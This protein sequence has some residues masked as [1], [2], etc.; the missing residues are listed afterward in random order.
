MRES[1]IEMNCERNN[2]LPKPNYFKIDIIIGLMILALSLPGFFHYG[3]HPD[4]VGIIIWNMRYWNDWN[5]KTFIYPSLHI[6]SVKIISLLLLD[7]AKFKLKIISEY[8]FREI[9]FIGRFISVLLAIGSVYILKRISLMTIRNRNCSTI[10]VFYAALFPLLNNICRFATLDV[11][12]LF[13]TL[14]AIWLHMI[15]LRKRKT[16][17]YYLTGIVY[18][19]AISV[20]YVAISLIPAF[21]IT[22]ILEQ[23]SRLRNVRM[24]VSQAFIYL[25]FIILGFL[26]GT[27][28]VIINWNGFLKDFIFL[29]TKQTQYAGKNVPIGFIT[30]LH[31]MH[32]YFYWPILLMALLGIY[33]FFLQRRNLSRYFLFLCIIFIYIFNGR[34]RFNPPRYLILL[35]M[36]IIII[37]MRGYLVVKYLFRKYRSMVPIRLGITLFVIIPLILQL[38]NT[39]AITYNFIHES[40]YESAQWFIMN[41]SPKEKIALPQSITTYYPIKF[42]PEQKIFNIDKIP[43][44]IPIAESLSQNNVK[45]FMSSSFWLR[46]FSEKE[47]QFL[48][49]I[50]NDRKWHIVKEFS[51]RHFMGHI[52]QYTEFLNPQIIIY[53]RESY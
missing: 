43:K 46:Q 38:R 16:E 10:A 8:T 19:L 36:F 13:W 20:K 34:T 15:A 22:L 41:T 50:Q 47:K 30:I 26:I 21:L 44:E 52:P 49:Q 18:G 11:A 17:L 14:M 32:Y 48:L 51:M 37:S 39:I 24:I 27:P 28:Y 42:I 25:L 3:D 4:E 31:Q 40:R 53:K 12:N 33:N 23:Y 29:A 2:V 1:L 9:N 35:Y 5:P 7:I 6:Y 45:Y